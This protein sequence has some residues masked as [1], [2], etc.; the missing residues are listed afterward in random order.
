MIYEPNNSRKHFSF[1]L[2]TNQ[3]NG[4]NPAE[5]GPHSQYTMA[6]FTIGAQNQSGISCSQPGTVIRNFVHINVPY[7]FRGTASMGAL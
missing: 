3:L 5:L 4:I 2:T 6:L 1:I 7:P